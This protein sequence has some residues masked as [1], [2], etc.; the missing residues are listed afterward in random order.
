M[1]VGWEILGGFF[2]ERKWRILE[3]ERDSDVSEEKR[4]EEREREV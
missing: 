4:R 2:R 1:V 3:R